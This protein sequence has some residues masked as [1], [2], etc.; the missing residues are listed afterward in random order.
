[1]QEIIRLSEIKRF[2]TVSA[3]RSRPNQIV[4]ELFNFARVSIDIIIIIRNFGFS[5]VLD[6]QLLM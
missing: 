5:G 2:G 4:N 1:M 3:E 6:V